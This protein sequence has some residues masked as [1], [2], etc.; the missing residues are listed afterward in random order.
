MHCC[1]CVLQILSIIVYLITPCFIVV[2]FIMSCLIL[3]DYYYDLYKY[4]DLH[5][6]AISKHAEVLGEET[7]QQPGEGRISRTEKKSNAS[8][9]GK[10]VQPF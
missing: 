1:E 5:D 10:K 4:Y 7:K 3:F 2:C 8:K 6:A 9:I